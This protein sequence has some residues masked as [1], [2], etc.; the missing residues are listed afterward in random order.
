M[1]IGFHKLIATRL[2]K[3]NELLEKW[4]G[5]ICKWN[6]HA[7]DLET[8]RMDMIDSNFPEIV[9]FLKELESVFRDTPSIA[10]CLAEPV[11]PGVRH[12]RVKSRNSKSQ[13]ISKNGNVQISIPKEA[14]DNLLV[15]YGFEVV[16]ED[17]FDFHEREGW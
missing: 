17:D 13:S 6:V 1:E 16:E 10:S 15:E 2:K 8:I 7:D 4:C 3:Y 12:I 9:E 5:Q 14:L 11:K